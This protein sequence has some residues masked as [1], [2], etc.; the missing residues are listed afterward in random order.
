MCMKG[1]RAGALGP[2]PGLVSR[3]LLPTRPY[4][5][6]PHLKTFP[7]QVSEVMLSDVHPHLQPRLAPPTGP[8]LCGLRQG[9]R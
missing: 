9:S 7:V 3:V 6:A 1:S 5:P 8:L 2:N 4:T